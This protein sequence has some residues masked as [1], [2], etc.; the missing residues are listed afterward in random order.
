MGERIIPVHTKVAG[1]A[2]F[3]VKGLR[4]NPDVKAILTDRLA[5]C[6]DIHDIS[7]ST[8]TG[9]VL[10]FFSIG[11]S[12]ARIQTLIETALQQDGSFADADPP[13]TRRQGAIPGRRSDSPQNWHQMPAD[14]VLKALD[15][16][17]SHGLT[18]SAALKNLHAAG[19]NI[20]KTITPRL[21]TEIFVG[22]LL[23]LPTLLLFAS[24]VIALISGTWIEA[25][26]LSGL[27][28][29]NAVF[30]YFLEYRT[31]KHIA[32]LRTTAV[33]TVRV[34][35]N[36]VAVDL[37]AESLVTGDL[38][39]LGPGTYIGADSRIVE[40][41][42]LK[43][44]ESILT[45]ES[46][47]VEKRAEMLGEGD[48]PVAG[49]LNM[50]F[51]GTLVV[52]GEG[53]C[54][55]VA[56][57]DRTQ[58]GRIQLLMQ[59]TFPPVTPQVI[60]LKQLSNQL[61]AAGM[62]VCGF[63]MGLS[64]IR[65]L[66]ILR[67]LNLFLS[68][69][70]SAIPA[71]LPSVANLSLALNMSRLK[72]THLS[73]QRLY[74]FETLGE[75]NLVCFDKTGTLTRSRI[76]VQ[77][78]YTGALTVAVENRRLAIGGKAIDPAAYIELQRLILVCIL[79]NENRIEFSPDGSEVIL[80]GSPTEKA[81][82][83]LGLLAGADA[84]RIYDAYRLE[85]V[86]HRSEKARYMVTLHAGPRQ[87]RLMSVKGNPS[88]VLS[89]C[90]RRMIDGEITALRPGDV[91]EI[92]IQNERMAGSALRV[93]GFA[94]KNIPRSEHPPRV[95]DLV[96]VGLVGMMEPIRMGVP[97][98]IAALHAG[99]IDT[100]MITG[101]Q[102][103]TAYSVAE[104][105]DIAAGGVPKMLDSS[106]VSRVKPG[107]M[108]ALVKNVQVFSRVNPEQKLQIVRAY[109]QGGKIVAM[110]GDGINDGPA[111]LAADIGIAMGLS[112]TEVA[113]KTSD[114]VLERDNITALNTAIKESRT[115]GDNVKRS[116]RYL[117]T[118]NFS[119]ML[120]GLG[121]LM[122]P[123]GPAL[124][125]YQP[126]RINFFL[127]I[128][129]SL[130]LLDAPGGSDVMQRGPRERSQPLFSRSEFKSML[131]DATAIA[132][133]AFGGLAYGVGRYKWSAR[134]ATIGW[135]SLAAAKLSH[136]LI[137]HHRTLETETADA[138]LNRMMPWALGVAFTFQALPFFVPGLRRVLNL[139][140]LS[141]VDFCAVGAASLLPFWA[142]RLTNLS[143]RISKRNQQARQTRRSG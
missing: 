89:L 117:L 120:V 19:P 46:E 65:G 21:G 108:Q 16:D 48:I 39:V 92:E 134:T 24:V 32:G 20:L 128:V 75:V 79:C 107:L 97:A 135:Q 94:Y 70:A 127:D 110:T 47:P 83:H 100:V 17:A 3:F 61:L 81:L 1:R 119:E 133:G 49:R 132:A 105:I 143:P 34:I 71:G 87:V 54:V 112:G 13:R 109:Q 45:G 138:R 140:E 25:A 113:R 98:M 51:M 11:S 58:F 69:A 102:G 121:A 40:A 43:I 122:L 74:A 78:I 64:L 5:S 141:A 28:L 142:R 6:A 37:S 114:I 30:G 7:A 22:Q 14:S 126:S 2:R 26:I 31:E 91:S 84:S 139:A 86:Q 12:S 137:V 42:N 88:T 111:L 72:K 93:L 36:G 124:I 129:P 33:P 44:D 130:A 66:G 15:S 38:L 85:S 63:T 55:V 8:T 96:W 60:R 68:M 131:V 103:L 95:E 77:E 99:G 101:D 52:G 115:A 57:G 118:A 73:L 56:T 104:T 106:S 9:N 27:T 59:E 29:S 80:H 82:L 53:L 123:A 35:R 67:A 4:N 116:I 10:V 23:S 125:Q 136:A 76:S 90:R 62:L 50:A 18:S 41:V